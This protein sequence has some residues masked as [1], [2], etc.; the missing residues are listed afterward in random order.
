MAKKLTVEVEAETTK[1]RRKLQELAQT[2]G[3]PAGADTVGSAAKNAA[4]GLDNAANA[5][6]KL[7][8]ATAEGSANLRAMTKVFGGMAIRMAT[9][10]A[11]SNMEQGSTGQMAVKGLGEVAGGA[12]AGAAFG[13]VGALAGGLMGLTSA[14]M[15]AS[16]AEKERQQRIADAT[17]DYEKSE[18]DYRSSKDFAEQL[19]GL[20]EVDKGFTDFSGRIQQINDVLKHY[21]EVEETLKSKIEGFIKSG[22]L[23]KANMER[24]YLSSN[25]SRQDQLVAA[26]ERLEKMAEN[27]KPE[28][29]VS[30]AALDSLAKI[31]GNFAGSESGFRNLQ[32]VNEKQVALLEKIEAK[33]GKGAG[34]F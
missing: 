24:G 12:I 19:K 30:T 11:A 34:T 20:T 6:N 7:S 27:Q 33:T 18:H 13:P 5:A 22:D 25:R 14:L 15:E 26:R 16:Q 9:G 8:K 29:R 10:Y 32:R 17:F 3:S 2:G 1:A 4:R 21:Q 23:E 31:G 28:E